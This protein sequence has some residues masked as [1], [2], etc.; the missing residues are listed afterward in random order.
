MMLPTITVPN[1]KKKKNY[2]SSSNTF[3]IIFFTIFISECVCVFFFLITSLKFYQLF[4]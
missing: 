1:Q 2:K 3:S 4:N